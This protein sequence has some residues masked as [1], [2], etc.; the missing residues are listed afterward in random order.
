MTLSVPT[1]PPS[2]FKVTSQQDSSGQDQTGH[3]VPGRMIYFVTGNGTPGS[4]FIPLTQYTPANVI[5]AVASLAQQID[6]VDAIDTR[7]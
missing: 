2:G 3:Y 1:P 7:S 5:A 4:V 6:S